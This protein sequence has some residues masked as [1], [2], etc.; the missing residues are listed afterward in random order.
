M[1]MDTAMEVFSG[2]GL[3]ESSIYEIALK[4]NAAGLFILTR[5]TCFSQFLSIKRTIM[6]L[7]CICRESTAPSTSS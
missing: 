6:S 3:Q 4:A 1:M 7:N 2:R 5:K